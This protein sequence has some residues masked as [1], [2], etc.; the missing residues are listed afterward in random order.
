[1]KE[2]KMKRLIFIFAAFCIVSTTMAQDINDY[3]VETR[4]DTFVIKPT[5][6]GPDLTGINALPNAILADTNDVGLR[7]NPNRVYLLL[8]GEYYLNNFRVP[9]PGGVPLRIIGEAGPEDEHPA[10]VMGAVRADGVESE[11]PIAPTTDCYLENLYINGASINNEIGGQP[12][13]LSADNIKLTMKNCICEYAVYF[14]EGRQRSGISLHVTDCVFLNLFRPEAF[15]V[16]NSRVYNNHDGLTEEMYFENNTFFNV[17]GGVFETRHMPVPSTYFNHNTFVNCNQIIFWDRKYVS[18]I[19]TNNLFMNCAISPQS[20]KWMFGTNRDP[21]NDGFGIINV[22]TLE[23]NDFDIAGRTIP[24]SERKYLVDKNSFWIDPMFPPFWQSVDSLFRLQDP[25]DSAS[26]HPGTWMNAGTQAIFD[27]DETW[28]YMQAY[29]PL[30]EKADFANYN[31][32]VNIRYI[33]WWYDRFDEDDIYEDVT[34]DVNSRAEITWPI[35]PDFS[36]TNANLLQAGYD[37]MPLGDLNWF[38]EKKAQWDSDAERANLMSI[39]NSGTTAVTEHNTVKP[40]QFVLEQNYPNPFNPSTVISFRLDKQ[41]DVRLS[42]YNLLGQEIR[43]LVDKTM[44]TGRHTVQWDGTNAL[45]QQVV[46]GVYLYK[47]SAG[48]RSKTLKMLLV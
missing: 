41:S 35:L 4:G 15:T 25:P 26:G 5:E 6:L 37:G 18:S 40:V 39:L 48:T 3:L 46:S 14:I 17:I 20:A 32:D 12:I 1:M 22:D 21:E 44:A 10:V 2:R 42:V 11:C 16:S 45:G 23:Q 19:V 27:D 7:D 29:P 8:R 9:L 24:P 36:Y 34:W 33:T 47:L 13:L 31:E 28:P 30:N 43:T 38:P